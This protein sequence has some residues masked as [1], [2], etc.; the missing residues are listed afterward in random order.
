MGKAVEIHQF[1]IGAHNKSFGITALKDGVKKKWF[2]RQYVPDKK[3]SDVRYEHALLSYIK[4]RDPTLVAAPIPNRNGHTYLTCDYEGHTYFYAIFE[5][6]EGEENDYSWIYNILPEK[7][8]FSAAR[9]LARYHCASYGFVPPPGCAPTGG[10][11]ECQEAEIP[12]RARRSF[13]AP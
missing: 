9:A 7:T 13:A 3:E 8:F 2:G 4:Q 1:T 5:F 10:G 6:L 12:Q 11:P